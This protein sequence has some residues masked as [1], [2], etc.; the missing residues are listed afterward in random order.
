M[1]TAAIFSKEETQQ[2]QQPD[3]DTTREGNLQHWNGRS[4]QND[5]MN[6]RMLPFHHCG[7]LDGKSSPFSSSLLTVEGR[8]TER[9]GQ[10]LAYSNQIQL[11]QQ[12]KYLLF[13]ILIMP[14][15]CYQ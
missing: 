10:N 13:L 11:Q 15:T 12:Q 7:D 14:G 2:Q 3:N 8:F 1:A 9:E 5:N 6:N 4:N